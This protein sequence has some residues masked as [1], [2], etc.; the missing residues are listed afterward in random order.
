MRTVFSLILSLVLAVALCLVFVATGVLKFNGVAAVTKLKP[1]IAT[2]LVD[3]AFSKFPD[4]APDLAKI[5]M[6]YADRQSLIHTRALEF[7]RAIAVKGGANIE[8]RFAKF[9][10]EELETS[11][12]ETATLVRM[13]FWKN[14]V[15]L[16]FPWRAGDRE[17]MQ[18]T[19]D[20]EKELK[21]AGFGAK[22]LKLMS[23][24]VKESET[25]LQELR[26]RLSGSAAGGHAL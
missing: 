19:F 1:P 14:F 4:I 24:E 22:G 20:R 11:E 10:M 5:I 15:T 21:K 7:F 18:I 16:Q 25:H 13:S 2:V 17:E 12:K 23:N 8:E 3:K 6:P 26:M 9:L